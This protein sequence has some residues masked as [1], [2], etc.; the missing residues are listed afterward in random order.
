M[1]ELQVSLQDRTEYQRE[2]EWKA[3][4]V[5]DDDIRFS[6]VSGMDA[7]DVRAL[8][9]FAGR[10]FLIMVRCPKV[11]AR[12]WHGIVPPKPWATKQKTGT[13]GVVVTDKGRMFVSDYDLMSVWRGTT[14]GYQK[15]F[16][17]A[18]NG[19][20]RG[21]WA[22]EAMAII[23]ALNYLLVSRIQ[24]GCQDDFQSIKNPGVKPTDHFAVFCSGAVRHL[25]DP[26]ACAAFYASNNLSWPYSP[27][28]NFIGAMFG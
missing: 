4:G 22:P 21:K 16:V 9:E 2:Q 6:R 3:A 15:V 19:A 26:N 11:E 23:V 14:N 13:S 17:S 8:R 20:V 24:H 27:N 5:S 1:S 12:A 28:G 18:A 10:G 25:Q 7:R